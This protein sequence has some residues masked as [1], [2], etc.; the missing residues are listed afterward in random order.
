MSINHD[1]IYFNTNKFRLINLILVDYIQ[2]TKELNPNE[3]SALIPK[4]LS[5]KFN[6]KGIFKLTENTM[7]TKRYLKNFFA[8]KDVK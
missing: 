6:F 5:L 7:N 2:L 1:I 8:K 3:P 4:Y